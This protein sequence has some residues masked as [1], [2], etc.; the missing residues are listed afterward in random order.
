MTFPM[1]SQGPILDSYAYALSLF[2]W[3]GKTK[4]YCFYMLLL[5]LAV[6]RAVMMAA[7]VL[8][9]ARQK[10]RRHIRGDGDGGGV[11]AE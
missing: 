4:W 8:Q 5:N 3:G 1:Y 2:G 6:L 10:G 9:T 7:S 11:A